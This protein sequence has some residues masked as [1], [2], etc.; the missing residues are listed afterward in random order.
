MK[1]MTNEL[2]LLMLP[3]AALILLGILYVRKGLLPTPQPYKKNHS[4]SA[5]HTAERQKTANLAAGIA[6]LIAGVILIVFFA[7]IP[8]GEFW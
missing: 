7:T 3:G 1:E 8:F 5:E 6:L 4:S 2:F